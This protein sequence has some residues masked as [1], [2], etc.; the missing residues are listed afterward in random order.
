M[1]LNLLPTDETMMTLNKSPPFLLPSPIETVGD[2]VDWLTE[3][4]SASAALEHL[5]HGRAR[6]LLTATVEQIAQHDAETA[7][8]RLRVER[9]EARIADFREREERRLADLERRQ[10]ERRALY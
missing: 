7:L 1:G 10:P 8:M 2:L 9:A 6:M 5:Q 3:Q 4:S